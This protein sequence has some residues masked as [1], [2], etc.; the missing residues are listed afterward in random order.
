[1]TYSEILWG[2]QNTVYGFVFDLTFDLGYVKWGTIKKIANEVALLILLVKSYYDK[3]IN[4]YQQA[5]DI[6]DLNMFT[7]LIIDTS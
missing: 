4:I 1:M 5:S 3:W 2:K 7:P 6:Q